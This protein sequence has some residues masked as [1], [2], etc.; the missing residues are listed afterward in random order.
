MIL[1]FCTYLLF[2]LLMGGLS[3]GPQGGSGALSVILG[4]IGQQLTVGQ[5]Y[6]MLCGLCSCGDTLAILGCWGCQ[7]YC[8][9]T[10]RVLSTDV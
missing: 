4:Q 6:V 2:N 8:Q 5:R 1:L 7:D 10:S 9:G 3:S